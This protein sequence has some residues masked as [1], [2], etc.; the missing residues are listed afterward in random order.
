MKFTAGYWAVRPGFSLLRGLHIVDVREEEGGLAALVST[1]RIE[2]RGDTLNR[3]VLRVLLRAVAEGVIGV[4]VSHHRGGVD[5]PPAFT[6][7]GDGVVPQI[8]ERH[9]TAGSLTARFAAD[10][11]GLTFEEG[12][13]VVTSS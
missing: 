11:W 4:T 10:E 13:R 9:L 7:T 12:G 5:R 1:K 3:P 2:G 8:G 6:L